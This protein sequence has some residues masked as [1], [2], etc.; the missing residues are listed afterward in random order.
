MTH[1]WEWNNNDPL[2]THKAGLGAAEIQETRSAIFERMN[3]D[4]YM[5][6]VLIPSS[7][8]DGK[9]KKVTLKMLSSD[10]VIISGAGILYSKLADNGHV[11][12]FFMNSNGDVTQLTN[13]GEPV[14]G[15]PSYGY[16]ELLSSITIDNT[17]RIIA[18]ELTSSSDGI[19]YED[20]RFKFSDQDNGQY[21]AYLKCTANV[22]FIL[23][24]YNETT[25]YAKF[26]FQYYSTTDQNDDP[27]ICADS[28][29]MFFFY[30]GDEE[31]SIQ[32][33]NFK[34]KRLSGSNGT[35]SDMTF[36]FI[37]I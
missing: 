17:S 14:A 4:H 34:I 33:I 25:L 1:E 26:A 22:P 3:V 29:K 10:P 28:S 35:L 23:Y 31:S 24:V 32:N 36:N 21:I 5:D 11:E 30:F 7:D 15:L 2:D 12:L 37:K 27:V 6:G 19:T 9:H 20:Y 8:Q 18:F 13:D 16:A